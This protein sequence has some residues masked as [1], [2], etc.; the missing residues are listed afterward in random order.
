VVWVAR[1]AY[2]AERELEIRQHFEAELEPYGKALENAI[3]RRL[4]LIEGFRAFVEG[5]GGQRDFRPSFEVFAFG[6]QTSAAG[7]R[8]L[9]VIDRGV[10]RHVFPREGNEENVGFDLARHPGSRLTSGARRAEAERRTVVVGP[11]ASESAG[12][13]LTVIR[14]YAAPP[15]G[16]SGLVSLLLDVEPIAEEAGLG[17]VTGLRV[18][19]RA[20]SGLHLFGDS[21][22]LAE[23][24]VEY[25]VALPDGALRLTA[26]P[27]RG[28][29]GAGP[30]HDRLVFAAGAAIVGLL[31]LLGWLIATRQTALAAAVEERTHSL[32]AA[33]EELQRQIAV[34]ERIEAQ[35]LQS[36]KM[37]G[38]GRLAGG[39][40]HDFNNLLTAILGYT[41]LIRMGLRPGDAVAE[42]VAEV[43]KAARRAADLTR[44][45]LAFARK[46]VVTPRVVSLNELVGNLQR[47]LDR[48]IG[49]HVM[50]ETELAPDL[51][52][53]RA[54]A[55]QLEQVVTNLVVNARDAL[56]R[57]GTVR[58]VTRNVTL[59]PD[60]AAAY[61]DLPAGDYVRLDVADSG[62]GMDEA[63]LARVFEP[64]FTTKEKGKGT[65]L[66]LATAYGI[67]RQAGGS[68][69]ANSRPGE[70]S[71]FTVLLPRVNEPPGRVEATPASVAA[72]GGEGDETVLV[73]DDEAPVRDI[74]VRALRARGYRVLPAGDGLEA[75]RVA[76][77][78]EALDL[79]VADVQMP[80]L[81]GR[82]LAAVLRATRPELRVLY[83]SGRADVA[84]QGEEAPPAGTDFLPKPF[85][86]SQLAVAVR[87]LLDRANRA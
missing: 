69:S 12:P 31:A 63:T 86:P 71:T 36:Q 42:D 9:Q 66:G 18:A 68:V 21:T 60:A 72:A 43:E 59:T 81:D 70:G 64:F 6:L 5:E 25:V 82:E 87:A 54:D 24:P 28:W 65:G 79:L 10:I 22:V 76:E 52:A 35:L 58:L 14:P 67:V 27:A 11:F 7:I 19:L 17:Q 23:L 26:V 75:Q 1:S 53:V 77:E 48:L 39:I 49:P 84:A 2:Q 47:L 46:Q 30:E 61:A 80:G 40:A 38:I 34:R 57:G 56:P 78:A 15:G 51:W 8:A 32:T 74:A 20:E 3:N 4:A 73:V 37:E 44:Q 16:P 50:L 13:R 83:I 62:E 85:T 33:Y 55:G 41:A 29:A 45:L